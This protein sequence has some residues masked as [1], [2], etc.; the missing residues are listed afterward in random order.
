MN[1]FPKTYDCGITLVPQNKS[2]DCWAEC[3][4]GV[5]GFLGDKISQ[6]DIRIKYIGNNDKP[7]GQC[8]YQNVLVLYNISCIGPVGP[9][10]L[11]QLLAEIRV[12][13]PQPIITS[14]A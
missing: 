10:S 7:A 9:L 5:L 3:C 1:E 11:E 8:V 2:E 13:K 14:I 6:D 4:S 12:D